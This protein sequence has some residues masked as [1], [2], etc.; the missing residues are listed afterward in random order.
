MQAIKHYL[1][2][3]S[4]PQKVYEAITTKHGFANWWTPQTEIENK[5]D[6]INIFRFWETLS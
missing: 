6:D 3:E 1:I 2:I 4:S 5:T